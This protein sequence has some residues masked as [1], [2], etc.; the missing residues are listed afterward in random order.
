MRRGECA[1]LPPACHRK[2]YLTSFAPSYR[3]ILTPVLF[4]ESTQVRR[5]VGRLEDGEEVVEALTKLCRDHDVEA[6]EIRAIGDLSA[7]ELARFDA[8]AKKYV[9]DFE[10][11]GNFQIVSM[12]GNVSMLGD[13]P[14]LRLETLMSVKG[15]A[16]IQVVSGQLR[17]GIARSCEFVLEIYEDLA[18]ERGMDSETGMLSLK[19]IRRTEEKVAAAPAPG[20]QAQ[21]DPAEQP[22]ET[23]DPKPIAGKGMSWSDAAS[24]KAESGNAGASSSAEKGAKQTASD[25]YG[26]LSFDDELME[27]GDILEHPKLGRCRIMKVE[28]GEYAHVRLPR[29]KIRKLSLEIVDV[30]LEGEEDGRKIFKAIINR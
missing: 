1:S 26:D 6:A 21:D 15:P 9:T 17:S 20:P 11:E 7:V 28:D 14:A 2:P 25:I 27:P 23:P 22:A 5:I 12:T 30:E 4:Q 19:S 16:G 18:M 24:E 29:G 10:G 8:D 3:R 13:A